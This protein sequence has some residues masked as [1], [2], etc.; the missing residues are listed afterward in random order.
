MVAIET[1]QNTDKGVHGNGVCKCW[2]LLIAQV[3]IKSNSLP[4]NFQMT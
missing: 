4:L 2:L 3:Y 1:K